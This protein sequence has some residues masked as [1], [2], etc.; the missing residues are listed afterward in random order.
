MSEPITTQQLA[1]K[2]KVKRATVS[3]TYSKFGSFKGYEQVG[4]IARNVRL[5]AFK[6]L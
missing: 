1:D 6:G 5:W 3:D 4:K 2:F